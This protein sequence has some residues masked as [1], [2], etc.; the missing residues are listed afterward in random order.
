MSARASE[1]GYAAVDLGAGSGR[2]V[3]GRFGRER[4]EL[5]VVHR[6]QNG[7]RPSAGHERWPVA[8]LQAGVEAG[9][10]RLAGA[11]LASVGVDGFG[12][13]Y[14]LLDA[15]GELVEEPISYRD[16]RTEGAMEAVFAR[17]PRAEIFAATGIQFLPINTLYQLFAH[18]QGGGWPTQAR[19]LLL[20]ADWF[21]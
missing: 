9:L 17:V 16:A 5:D 19:R 8:E 12:V 14:A 15:R 21:A 1:R 2:V 20:L 10:A 4:L 13:D 11:R 3:Y 18:V 7:A 6:F